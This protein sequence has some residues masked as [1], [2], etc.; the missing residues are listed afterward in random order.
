[1]LSSATS[2]TRPCTDNAFA[3][4][5]SALL[6]RGSCSATSY[7]ATTSAGGAE[8]SAAVAFCPISFS[9]SLFVS[10]RRCIECEGWLSE[11][12]G[13]V[14]PRKPQRKQA[15][16][17]TA[18]AILALRTV[19][20][21]LSM[22]VSQHYVRPMA[23]ELRQSDVELMPFFTLREEQMLFCHRNRILEVSSHERCVETR[24][25]SMSRAITGQD[26]LSSDRLNTCLQVTRG[27]HLF[28]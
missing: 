5:D 12:D 10:H 16:S 14:R 22:T 3:G 6:P 11:D 17:R 13:K 1:M 25:G 27:R 24:G 23:M 21:R 9:T 2:A 20:I 15:Q 18:A 8:F 26:V 19:D 7:R 28:S 4:T